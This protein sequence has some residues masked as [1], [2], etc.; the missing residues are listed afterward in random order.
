MLRDLQG[1]FQKGKGSCPS[2]LHFILLTNI[3]SNLFK[4]KFEDVEVFAGAGPRV[5]A[6]VLERELLAS[7]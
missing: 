5:V 1:C 2:Q 4:I 3:N 7:S 6:T